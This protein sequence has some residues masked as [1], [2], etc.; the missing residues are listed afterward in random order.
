MN[1]IERIVKERKR[2]TDNYRWDSNHDKQHEDESLALAACYY[3]L[4]NKYESSLLELWP[5]SWSVVYANK[6]SGGRIRD[7]EKAGALIAAEI[8]RIIEGKVSDERDRADV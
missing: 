6:H 1:G 7:L 3:A 2:Q 8:D 5:K 4:P